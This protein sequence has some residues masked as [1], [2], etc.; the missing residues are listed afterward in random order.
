MHLRIVA[1]EATPDAVLLRERL[2]PVRRVLRLER[3][4]NLVSRQHRE[5]DAMALVQVQGAFA[6]ADRGEGVP[7][8]PRLTTR[9]P[10]I[11]ERGRERIGELERERDAEGVGAWRWV[12]AAGRP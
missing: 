8:I 5:R 9:E 3:R 2:P 10:A 11:V 6:H 12:R 1:P 7:D 4:A